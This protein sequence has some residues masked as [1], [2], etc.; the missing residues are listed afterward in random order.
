MLAAEQPQLGLLHKFIDRRCRGGQALQCPTKFSHDRIV[1]GH[2]A[3]VFA[4]PLLML[5]E[6]GHALVD[7]LERRDGRFRCAQS[8]A[9][10]PQERTR[11]ACRAIQGASRRS[12]EDQLHR[13]AQPAVG[14]KPL[15]NGRDVGTADPKRLLDVEV[16]KGLWKLSGSHESQMNRTHVSPLG[17]AVVST[18]SAGQ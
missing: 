12:Q 3:G 9:Q 8:G 5:V 13:N 6:R 15:S 1:S 16:R 7:G 10:G 2:D 14:A 4:R 18:I 17:R 11:H